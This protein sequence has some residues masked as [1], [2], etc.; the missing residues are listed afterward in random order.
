MNYIKENVGAH[1]GGFS[2]ETQ[3]WRN[4]VKMTL[5]PALKIFMQAI[6][7][8]NMLTNNFFKLTNV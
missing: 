2:C 6:F 7:L 4:Q 5:T 8:F 1:H 3:I